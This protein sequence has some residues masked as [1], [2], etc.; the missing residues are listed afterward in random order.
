MFPPVWSASKDVTPDAY[1]RCVRPDA[2]F[3]AVQQLIRAGLNDCA[4]SR[5]TKIPRGTVRDWRH[6]GDRNARDSQGNERVSGRWAGGECPICG[7]RSL[8]RP[9]Y[10]YLLGLYLGDGFIAK[11]HRGVF[12][13]RISLDD[14]YPAIIEECATAMSIVRGRNS[15]AP[16][17]VQRIGCTEVTSYWK[18][19]PCLFPQ[20]EAGRKHLRPVHLEWWQREIVCG[21]P[22]RLLRGLIQSDGC[23]DL[24][25]VNG[26]SYP[27]YQFSNESDDIRSIFI[28]ACELLGIHWTTPSYKV[29]SVSRRPDVMKLDGFIGPKTRPV[30]LAYRDPHAR[31]S[32]LPLG[33][34]GT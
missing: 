3:E 7:I 34:L 19:W 6:Q 29:V 23:R 26:K 16:G 10:A 14:R 24:N 15:T 32:Q 22:E 9:W 5:A 17:F 21:C 18:H 27:R 11:H 1:V 20:H 33:L 28:D 2:E 30:P 12:R 8:D 25:F 4:I 13:L 31:S